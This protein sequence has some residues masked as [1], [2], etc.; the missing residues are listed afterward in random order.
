MN[1]SAS[2]RSPNRGVVPSVISKSN[3]LVSTQSRGPK[4]IRPSPS[5]EA[6]TSPK[7]M[8]PGGFLKS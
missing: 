4:L 6:R 3:P 7:K 5:L 1:D 8:P 2:D